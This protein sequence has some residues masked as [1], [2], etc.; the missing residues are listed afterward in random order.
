MGATEYLNP[1]GGAGLY[2][3]AC[4][5]EHGLHLTIQSFTNMTYDCG[6][7]QYEPALSILDVMMWNSPEQ[8]KCYLDTFRSTNPNNR[9]Q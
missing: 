5:R 2:D 1:P 8:I 6:R 4:F 3:A 9:D 7:F